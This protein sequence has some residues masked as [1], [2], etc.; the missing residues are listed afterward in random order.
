MAFSMLRVHGAFGP[1]CPISRIGTMM[2]R[3]L[4]HRTAK[5]LTKA[6]LQTSIQTAQYSL[7]NHSNHLVSLSYFIR[8]KMVSAKEPHLPT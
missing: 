2:E 8:N 6:Y 4:H 5:L 1:N 7:K 3:R